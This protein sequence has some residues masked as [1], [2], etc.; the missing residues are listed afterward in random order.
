M[1]RRARIAFPVRSRAGSLFA[2][3]LTLI[4][5]LALSAAVPAPSTAAGWS[6]AVTVSAPHDM[7]GNLGL[8]S[9]ASADM[10][11]WRFYDL[12]LIHI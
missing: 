12:S 6:P 1:Q 3:A 11:S 5:A 2:A 9:G 7:I 4:G 10:V 8:A